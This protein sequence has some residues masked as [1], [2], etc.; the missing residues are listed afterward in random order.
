MLK[1]LN[2]KGTSVCTVRKLEPGARGIWE[3]CGLLLRWAVGGWVFRLGRAAGFTDWRI[4]AAIHR[5]QLGITLMESLS[6]FQH[7]Q[8]L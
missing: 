2:K 6:L 8:C 5:G 4:I 1:V 3:Q 7:S